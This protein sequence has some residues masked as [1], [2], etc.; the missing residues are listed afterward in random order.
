MRIVVGVE[1]FEEHEL[2]LLCKINLGEL[3]GKQEG[4]E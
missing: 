3:Q 4:L 1:I 2:N